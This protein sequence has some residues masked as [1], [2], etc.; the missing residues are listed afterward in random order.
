MDEKFLIRVAEDTINN[1]Q[2]LIGYEEILNKY[3]KIADLTFE[4]DKENL[5]FLQLLS[6][7]G[8]ILIYGDPGV[9]KTTLA[10]NIAKYILD[11]F[12]VET[13]TINIS[14]VVGNLLGES[15]KNLSNTLKELKEKERGAL[16]ILDEIDRFVI[17]RESKIENS[18]LKRM[19]LE[20]MDFLDNITINEKIIV[21]GI[22]NM[23]DLLDKAFLRRF[24]FI[25]EISSTNDLLYNFLNKILKSCD[26]EIKFGEIESNFFENYKTCDEIKKLFK[27]KYIE[28]LDIK[29]TINEIKK[30]AKGG[31]K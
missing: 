2:T 30:I 26:D 19:L 3:K 8:N 16:L 13:Y 18:E 1:F 17:D 12:G 5:A 20:L 22:T 6:M 9:G 15:T 7:N 23:K 10:Y 24:D 25:D 28:N 29:K 31:K 11:K 4:I 14:N 27:K 21:I